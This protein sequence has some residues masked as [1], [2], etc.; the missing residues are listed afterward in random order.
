M[1]IGSRVYAMLFI[2]KVEGQEQFLKMPFLPMF[3]SNLFYLHCE[4]RKRLINED[5]FIYF[6]EN[7]GTLSLLEKED[8]NVLTII[9]FTTVPL[10]S[11][12]TYFCEKQMINVPFCTLYFYMFFILCK[13]PT[14]ET[15]RQI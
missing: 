2:E 13:L 1:K 3:F 10:D 15:C 11:F 12:N 6:K 7:L 4:K 14:A 5:I 9:A 8:K